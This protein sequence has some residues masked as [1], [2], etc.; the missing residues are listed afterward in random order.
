MFHPIQFECIGI[1]KAQ[2]RVKAFSRG[3]R[4]GVYDPGTANDWKTVVR[5][6]CL[7]VWNKV[8]IDEPVAVEL[9][10]YLPRPKSHFKKSGELNKPADSWVTKKPD[11]DNLEKAVL[12]A[13]TDIGLWRDDSLVVKVSKEKVYAHCESG[14]QWSGCD[15]LI[16]RPED[17]FKNTLFEGHPRT[18]PA[19]HQSRCVQATQLRFGARQSRGRS[20]SLVWKTRT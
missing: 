9:I 2:P 7:E 11:L 13:L 10:F 18:L 19:S 8:V 5:N 20:L 12:D 14:S 1:P 4:A 15:V 17:F 6:A 3:G 16:C